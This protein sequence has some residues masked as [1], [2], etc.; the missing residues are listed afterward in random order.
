MKIA[1]FDL[2]TKYL[3]Q[4]LGI[5]RKNGDP[6]KLK[7]AVAGVLLDGEHRMFREEEVNELISFLKE[8]DLIVG[9][10]VLRFDF[11]VLQAYTSENLM[12]LF[13]QKTFD[14]LQELEKVTGKWLGLDDLAK[15][16]LGMSK[17]AET[18]LIPKMWRDG[19]EE[20]VISYLKNDLDMTKAVYEHG[21]KVG[22]F[23]Y[24]FKDYGKSLGEREVEVRWG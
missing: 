22:K 11:K 18:I 8:V 14:T 21:V 16:N 6:S 17:N 15:R 13:I 19:K 12:D 2:E 4:D 7:V 23:K 24:D 9:H 20:E 3:Y 1:F 5:D 10:N